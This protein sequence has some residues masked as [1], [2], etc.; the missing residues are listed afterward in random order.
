MAVCGSMWQKIAELGAAANTVNNESCSV[1]QCVAVC[2]SVLQC[3]AVCCSVLQ[4]VA[5]CCSVLQ[6]V[7]A[8]R[9]TDAYHSE[10]EMCDM[11]HPYVRHD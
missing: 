2:C 6:C 11:T 10:A 8:I 9:D 7:A 1:L 5:V 4:C 3:V